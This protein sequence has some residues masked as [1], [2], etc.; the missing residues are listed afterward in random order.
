[1]NFI[2]VILI[3]TIRNIIAT[4]C[5]KKKVN[6]LKRKKNGGLSHQGYETHDAVSSISNNL[7]LNIKY[8]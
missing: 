4:S 2:E 1:M 6:E 8:Y 3:K 5:I 7:N